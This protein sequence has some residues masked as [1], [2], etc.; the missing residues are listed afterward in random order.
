MTV[1][2]VTNNS[3][4]GVGSL[5]NAINIAQ[6][7]DTIKFDSSLSNQTITLKSSVGIQKSLTIDGKDAPNLTISGGQKTNIFRLAKQNESLTVRSVTLADSYYEATVGGAIWAT[8]NSTV[9]IENANFINNVSQG[10]AL[11]GQKGSVINVTNSTFDNNDGA[12]ISNKPYSAGAISLFA[13]GSLT[14]KGSVFTNNTGFSGGAI[15]VTSSDLI[16]EDSTFMGNDSTV[17]ADKNY[18]YIPGGG[19]AI[20]IDGA[21]VPDDPRFY[22]GPNQGE[23]EG[24]EFIVRNSRFESN[25][26]AGQGGA[27]VAWGYNQ[28]RILIEDSEI[29]NNEV[30]MSQ[31]GI[32]QAPM[33]QG[34]G[35][36]LMGFIEINNTT[37]ANNKSAH[38]GG[39]VHIWGEVPAKISNSDFSGNQASQGGAIYDGLWAS[40]LEINSTN[41]DSNSATNQGGVIY[42]HN[43]SVPLSLQNSQFTNNKTND[44]TDYR[45]GDLANVSFDSDVPDIRYGTYSNDSIVGKDGDSYL[46]GLNG[47]DTI[48]GNGGNDYLDGGANND[49]IFGEVGNDTLVGGNGINYLVG[50]DGN[51]ILSGGYGQDLMEGGNGAD[52]Y[53]L[54]DENR[55]FYTDNGW[56]DRATIKDFQ[57]EQDTI[58]LKGKVSDYTIK[59]VTSQGILG[60]GILYNNEMIAIIGNMTP[61]RFSLNADYIEVVG[62][63]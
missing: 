58:Q 31:Q 34:G 1:I 32:N 19:G 15:R 6:S 47:N 27:I 40:K 22:N 29:V 53:I 28:D 3:S 18:L 36:W 43:P 25:R 21:S 9:N 10:A 12:T 60:T 30:I 17:G 33:A 46:V 61:D 20:Y 16:V 52:K 51:D 14:V 59:P 39:G 24:G 57:P 55:I 44:I 38:L 2:T 35:L 48:F 13:Y 11:H 63:V 42:R 45:W 54:G 8:E 7:G 41:F 4:A 26:G 62:K 56:Y 23:S 37:I 5:R 50:G 49:T